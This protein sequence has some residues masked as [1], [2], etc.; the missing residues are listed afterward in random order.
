MLPLLQKPLFKWIP[1]VKHWWSARLKD[2]LVGSSGN[3]TLLDSFT[4]TRALHFQSWHLWKIYCRSVTWY[5]APLCHRFLQMGSP[6]PNLV[7]FRRRHCSVIPWTPPR[8][9][10]TSLFLFS[11]LFPCVLTGLHVFQLCSELILWHKWTHQW[12]LLRRWTLRVTPLLKRKGCR[13]IR[14]LSNLCWFYISRITS[15]S[16]KQPVQHHERL[17]NIMSLLFALF[18][19]LFLFSDL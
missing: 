16:L 1:I 18:L 2:I 19:S 7:T 8:S 17:H 13:L 11:S 12:S 10:S 15:G 6:P 4:H 5:S 3:E 9:Q 14:R